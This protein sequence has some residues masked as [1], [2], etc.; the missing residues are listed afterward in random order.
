MSG[1]FDLVPFHSGL[2]HKLEIYIY[3]SL[4]K[5]T[6]KYNFLHIVSMNSNVKK[7]SVDP[8]QLATGKASWFG[9]TRFTWF[10]PAFRKSLYIV[11]LQ[12]S[13]V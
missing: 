4:D 7:N 13:K 10:H 1:L 3:L 5:F 12:H 8:D 9:S 6:G 2:S 11:M